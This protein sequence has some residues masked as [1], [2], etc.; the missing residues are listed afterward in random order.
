MLKYLG[1]QKL[2]KNINIT[3]IIQLGGVGQ[4]ISIRGRN[5]SNPIMLFLHGGPGAVCRYYDPQLEKIFTIVNWDQRGAGNSYT[6]E[7]TKESIN[8]KQLL[9]DTNELVEY[10]K[11]EFNKDKIFL[12]GHSW[13]SFLGISTVDR[14]PD[15]FYAYI[16][17]AQVVN[18]RLNEQ[19]SYNY[20][21][22]IAR[23]HK[24]NQAIEELTTIARMEDGLYCNGRNGI[25]NERQWLYKLG[26]GNHR[27]INFYMIFN[28]IIS[29]KIFPLNKVLYKKGLY[30]S[31][32]NLW[33]WSDNVDLLNQIPQIKIPVFFLTGQYD[34][35]STFELVDKYYNQL[36]APLKE[37][38]WF[39]HSSHAPHIEEPI[40]FY[41][42]MNRIRNIA[43]NEFS[44]DI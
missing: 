28:Y 8:V 3:K 23:K 24:N 17:I 7:V 13:G 29:N 15:N 12:V 27:K 40:I 34:Y 31:A 21:L 18:G 14:Y 39:K 9:A 11:K 20:T 41:K 38:I 16:G 43:N 42:T 44:K 37:L 5:I 1:L 26:K 32:E 30:F 35:V 4:W 22:E 2:N 25:H 19:I 6:N 36:E 10:L 33:G